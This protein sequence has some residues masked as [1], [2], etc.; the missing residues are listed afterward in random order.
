MY[1]MTQGVFLF[2]GYSEEDE[3]HL[4]KYVKQE[5]VF[6]AVQN[7]QEMFLTSEPKTRC[8]LDLFAAFKENIILVAQISNSNSSSMRGVISDKLSLNTFLREKEECAD[9][10]KHIAEQINS[11]S[12]A[13]STH[14]RLSMFKVAQVDIIPPKSNAT[15]VFQNFLLC[16]LPLLTKNLLSNLLFF[17]YT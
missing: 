8:Y 2:L 1:N 14:L 15:S 4:R 5:G 13:I 12:N 6:E 7:L 16:F 11:H 3:E 17:R 9:P 10:M